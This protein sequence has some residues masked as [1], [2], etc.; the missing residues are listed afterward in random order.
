MYLF[1]LSNSIEELYFAIFLMLALIIRLRGNQLS[2]M[3][4]MMWMIIL[5]VFIPL[6]FMN[7]FIKP[8]RRKFAEQRSVDLWTPSVMESNTTEIKESIH[9]LSMALSVIK[10]S[11]KLVLSLPCNQTSILTFKTNPFYFLSVLGI[12]S[13]P[14]SR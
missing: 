3:L 11:I 14:V 6:D 13:G 8:R 4:L 10:C 1:N 9:V 2:L 5:R 7:I 12:R